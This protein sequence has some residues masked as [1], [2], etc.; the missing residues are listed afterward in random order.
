M[1][2]RCR[3]SETER[4]NKIQIFDVVILD[5]ILFIC[6]LP[7]LSI[8]ASVSLS[9][10][11]SLSLRVTGKCPVIVDSGVSDSKL[12]IGVRRF[13]HMGI[14]MNTGLCVCVSLCLC[15]CVSGY[16]S[17]CTGLYPHLVCVLYVSPR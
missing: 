17:L 16:V 9:L 3:E 14:F 15:V 11:L 13:L 7:S 6:P 12:L 4:E 2:V 1:C 8:S 5:V 10:L